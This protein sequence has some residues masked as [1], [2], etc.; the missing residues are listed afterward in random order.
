MK[1]DR[2]WARRL[3]V[4]ALAFSVTETRAQPSRTSITLD[5]AVAF[6]LAHHPRMRSVAAQVDAA[7][8]RVDEART[9]EL[10]GLGVSAE[11]N[12]STGNTVPGAFFPLTGFPTISGA[13]RGRAFDGGA[14]QTGVSLWSTWDVTSV[15]EEAARVDLA[16]A[17]ASEARAETSV[18]RLE[19]AYGAADAFLA[20]LQAREGVK[21]A[22]AG[23]DRARVFATVVK[24]LV[25]QDLRPGVDAARADAELAL[26]ETDLARAEQFEMERRAAFVR[27]LGDPSSRLEPA[28]GAPPGAVD[29]PGRSQNVAEHPSVRAADAATLRSARAEGVVKLE[30]LPRVQILGAIWLRGSGIY[31]SPADG[32]VPDVPNW[33]AGATVSWSVLDIPGVEARAR[34]ARA[35][36]EGAVARRDETV[37]AV[38][39]EM[40]SATA[41]LRGAVNVARTTPTALVSARQAEQQALARY[42][43][44]LAQ[45]VEVADAERLLTQA[46]VND[47][48]ARLQVLRAELLVARAEGDLEPFFASM[49]RRGER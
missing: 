28:L 45:A 23:V 40:Q 4:L 14:F 44:A 25:A 22:R 16:L 41:A 32:I 38:A 39:S 9:T 10:P 19:I 48:L 13:P 35:E 15:L 2:V 46:E 8:S 7:H 37:L 27:A 12:R 43:S 31:G 3:G 34:A 29:D 30:Y 21:A 18:Q 49:R 11:I 6:A 17:G 36:H 26:A 20:L 42:R 47:A 5:E 24:S 1:G 33:A